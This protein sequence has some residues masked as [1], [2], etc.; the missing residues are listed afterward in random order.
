MPWIDNKY[1]FPRAAA[2][3]M[4]EIWP[5]P[6]PE[7]SPPPAPPPPI[8]PLLRVKPLL[9]QSDDGGDYMDPPDPLDPSYTA[10]P[11]L[12]GLLSDRGT[13]PDTFE[14]VGETARNIGK[15]AGVAGL[16]GGGPIA[17]GVEGLAGLSE[18]SSLNE[19]LSTYAKN[20]G[21]QNVPQIGLWDAIAAGFNPFEDL[22]DVAQGYFFDPNEVGDIWSDAGFDITEAEPE[23]GFPPGPGFYEAQE[24][25]YSA[26]FAP[27]GVTHGGYGGDFS[28]GADAETLG[29]FGGWGPSF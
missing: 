21:I 14:G 22:R 13:T 4:Q 10:T 3:N 11:G 27:A 23:E 24:A 1:I 26:V 6:W 15:V 18:M 5:W 8:N 9:P 2:A 25:D 29:D 28:S 12:L 7:E 16:L 17:W 19:A 20:A